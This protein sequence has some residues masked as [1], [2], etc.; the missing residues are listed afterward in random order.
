MLLLI[1]KTILIRLR[2]IS[3][4]QL[5]HHLFPQFPIYTRGLK[6]NWERIYK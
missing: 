2:K 5:F 1:H 3:D 4:Y 6:T